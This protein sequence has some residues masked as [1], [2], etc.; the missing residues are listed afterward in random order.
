MSALNAEQIFHE[1]RQLPPLEQAAYLKGACAHDP[2]LIAKVEN[3]LRADLEAGSFME[4]VTI[5]TPSGEESAPHSEHE[6]AQI[7]RYK[8]LQMIGEGGFGEV[9]MAE[10]REP[11]KRR[12]ALKIIKLGMDTRQVIARFEA[13]RQALA[14]MDHPNIAKVLDA[15]ATDTGRPYFVM[16]YI[17]GVPFL[18]YCDSEKLN[19]RERLDLFMTVCHAIQHAHQKGIIHRDIKPSNVMITMHDGVPVPKVIDF[20]IAKATN[21]ELTERTLFTQHRQMIGTPAYMSPEQAEMSGLDIDTRSDIYSLG[22]LLYE[23]LTGTTPMSNDELMSKGFAE[24]MRMIKETEPHKPS[25]R[26]NTLGMTATQTAQQRHATSAEQ[27]GSLLKGDLDWIVMKCLEKDRTRRY[28][29]AS[30]LSE[31]IRRHINDEPVLAGPPSASYKF[32]KLVKRNK[33]AF[34]AAAVVLIVLVLG[35]IGTSVGLAMAI[36]SQN[37]EAAQRALAEERFELA[38]AYVETV[39]EEVLPEVSNLIGATG[40][41]SVLTE[42]STAFLESLS[43]GEDDSPELRW[44]TAR[45]LNRLAIIQ[46]NVFASN[47]QGDFEA[48]LES[49]T[50]AL[51]IL[52][53][54][55]DSYPDPLEHFVTEWHLRD[56]MATSLSVT[57]QTE[58][59]LKTYLELETF[60]NKMVE[61]HPDLFEGSTRYGGLQAK[62]DSLGLNLLHL[63]IGHIYRALGEYETAHER[64]ARVC[65]PFL[66]A[67]HDPYTSDEDIVHSL[68]VTT[69]IMS[70]VSEALGHHD[71]ALRYAEL[72]AEYSRIKVD[73][74][75]NVARFARDEVRAI[76]SLARLHAS[77]GQ[78]ER[79]EPLVDEGVVLAQRIAE[80]DP[81]NAGAQIGA[82]GTIKEF[83][84]ALVTASKRSTENQDT[85]R[86]LVA[87]GIQLLMESQ[88]L[89]ASLD[90]EIINQVYRLNP[91]ELDDTIRAASE[92][93]DSLEQQTE[94]K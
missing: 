24:M 67:G 15:G 52:D 21:Q 40:P 4:M 48:S 62:G 88:T 58:K 50:R 72:D 27:L 5:D 16:E 7:G 9:W 41:T 20:G 81:L 37:R 6:G 85:A 36:A 31:D 1:A 8:L 83:G 11:V 89:L 73:R 29:S 75:P 82:V 94:T 49:V 19:P 70:E 2:S 33:S 23:L 71:D 84:S 57:G 42:A 17:R 80:S 93:L 44:L 32:R 61:K 90:P 51:E 79:V 13:E 87:R 54:L 43:V 38:R 78:I 86:S 12:V 60:Q 10:Q 56:K 69:G 18:E 34:L 25:T 65:I 55:D 68:T 26:L 63:R 22:V 35:V 76:S 28:E 39:S 64:Y 92:L 47:S 91:D 14:M 30:G 59:A 46:G 3:L 53:T 45:L 74:W 66:E 77:Y